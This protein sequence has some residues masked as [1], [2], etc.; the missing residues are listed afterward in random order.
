MGSEV[1]EVVSPMWLGF[2]NTKI[3]SMSFRARG[4]NDIFMTQVCH[5]QLMDTSGQEVPG[6]Y[7]ILEIQSTYT[8]TNGKIAKLV[9]EFDAA[10]VEASRKLATEAA[11]LSG[12][13]GPPKAQA[14]LAKCRET[15]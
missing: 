1:M 8:Y 14:N 15:F 9:Q 2:K 12:S 5:Q 10:K 4:D 13:M 7:H 6:A 3:E 11:G